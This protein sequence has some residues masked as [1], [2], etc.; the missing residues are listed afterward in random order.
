MRGLFERLVCWLLIT[1]GRKKW[2]ISAAIFPIIVRSLGPVG[3][4]RWAM[5]NLPAYE[6]AFAKY[7]PLRTNFICTVASL[8][9]GC[10]YCTYASGRAFEL[11][12]FDK[13]RKLFPMDAHDLVSLARLSDDE[14]EERVATA[15]TE[16]ELPDEIQIFR[17]LHAIK[18]QGAEP[19]PDEAFLVHAVQMFDTLNFC[20]IDA[21]VGIDDA[22]DPVNLD[23]ALKA[24]YAAARL[25]AGRGGTERD[26]AH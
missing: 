25:E 3:A 4:L 1:V 12:Y 18:L 20:A 19:Q 2:G 8:L 24:R 7:G 22:H 10:A 21:Q 26:D 5:Q 23:Q 16:A 14:V 13:Y 9:N 11:Y 17:R 6:R 15:L